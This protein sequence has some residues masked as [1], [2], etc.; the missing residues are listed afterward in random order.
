MPTKQVLLLLAC[1]SFTFSSPV[2]LTIS[3]NLLTDDI[4]AGKAAGSDCTLAVLV[5]GKCL[6]TGVSGSIEYY[7]RTEPLADRG[8]FFL[9]T[10]RI[11]AVYSPSGNQ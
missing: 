5:T 7:R 3:K 11:T 4:C 6:D 2:S 8:R 1:A 9:C 10:V